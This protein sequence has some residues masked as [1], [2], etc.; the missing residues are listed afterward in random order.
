MNTAL[1][2]EIEK[3]MTAD[4][5]TSQPKRWHQRNTTNIINKGENRRSVTYTDTTLF[6]IVTEVLAKAII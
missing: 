2:I 3:S 6:N 1:T 5:C 4:R